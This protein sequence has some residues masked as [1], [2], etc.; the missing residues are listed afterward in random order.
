MTAIF[1]VFS[2][3]KVK[4]TRLPFALYADHVFAHLQS[5]QVCVYRYRVT[6]EDFEDEVK[7]N[8]TVTTTVEVSCDAGE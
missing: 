6:Q 2:Y 3:A 8:A 4:F 7:M 5:N 1:L